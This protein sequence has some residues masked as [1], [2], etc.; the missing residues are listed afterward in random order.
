MLKWDRVAVYSSTGT[1]L[2]PGPC[3]APA[4]AWLRTRVLNLVLVRVGSFRWYEYY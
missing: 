4:W 3:R 2:L 1:Q